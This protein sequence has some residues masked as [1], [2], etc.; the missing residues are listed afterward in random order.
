M[1]KAQILVESQKKNVL[2][3]HVS[4]FVELRHLNTILRLHSILFI[5]LDFTPKIH[6][7]C[8]ARAR[9]TNSLSAKMSS[10]ASNRAA[11]T[12]KITLTEL[13]WHVNKRV[14]LDV[15]IVYLVHLLPPEGV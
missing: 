14:G 8:A 6:H 5:F 13:C 2:P 9:Q 12:W 7:V 15:P 4:F 1:A 11:S 10:A 3:Y